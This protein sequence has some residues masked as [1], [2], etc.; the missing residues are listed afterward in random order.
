VVAGALQTGIANVE[1]GRWLIPSR[2]PR[3]SVWSGTQRAAVVRYRSAA[4]ASVSHC[5]SAGS[6]RTS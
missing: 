4:S 1:P 2:S 5:G 6:A 3:V